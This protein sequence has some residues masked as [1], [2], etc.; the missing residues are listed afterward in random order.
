MV[1]GPRALSLPPIWASIGLGLILA[2][3]SWPLSDADMAWALLPWFAHIRAGGYP[4][5]FAAPFSNY[6]PPYLYVLTLV[7]PLAALLSPLAVIK[8]VSVI[9]HGLLA[10]AVRRLLIALDYPHPARAAALVA[11]APTL[12]INTALMA[13]CDAYWA[14][15]VVAG[16]AAAVER[17][18]AAMFVWLGL[19]VAFKLQAAF[20]GPFVLALGLSR[21]VP[22][23]LWLLSPIAVLLTMVPA[24][25][26]GWPAM[27]LLTIYFRQAQ[28]DIDVML[29]APNIWTL[30]E[31][32]PGAKTLPLAALATVAAIG[33]SLVY[34]IVFARRLRIDDDTVLL[35]AAL[36]C[37]LIV[38]GLLPRMHERYFLMA[39]VLALVV[40]IV[41]PGTWRSATYTQLGSGLALL[42]YM[43]GIAALASIGAA[44]MLAATWFALRPF[45]PPVRTHRPL[46]R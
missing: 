45:S 37:A 23:R 13:Q 32:I 2:W 29:N 46:R 31:A 22:L 39:D 20:V 7:S 35:D 21:G 33:A 36:L 24:W 10:L 42:A 27:D 5:A 25:L 15:G 38:P 14:A 4:G 44:A 8:L 11:L 30:V 40:L 19:A 18:H 3:S 16:L 1:A 43:T 17:R 28:W 12:F 26:A 34:V 9:G 41:R 6:A